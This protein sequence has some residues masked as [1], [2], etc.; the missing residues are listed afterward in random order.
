MLFFPVV[1]AFAFAQDRKN[2]F[3]GEQGG[4]IALVEADTDPLDINLLPTSP[5][6]L[7]SV[8]SF[9]TKALAYSSKKKMITSAPLNRGDLNQYFKIVL[10]SN[11]TFVLQH[12]DG[13]VGTQAGTGALTVVKC[14]DYQNVLQ[15]NK[16]DTVES[17]SLRNKLRDLDDPLQPLAERSLWDVRDK[18]LS[19]SSVGFKGR[20]GD[21]I[22]DHVR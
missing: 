15:L 6:G 19:E 22:P 8:L 1:R 21:G 2:L 7:S 17:L 18:L 11:G 4:N 20:G 14:T 12:D 3:I 9:G 5:E 10:I 13:C 16:G